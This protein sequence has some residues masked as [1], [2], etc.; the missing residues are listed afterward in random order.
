[1][2]HALNNLIKSLAPKDSVKDTT[3]LPKWI[4][5]KAGVSY[6]S[7]SGKLMDVTITEISMA[8]QTVTFTFDKDATTWKAVPFN[9]VLNSAKNPLKPRKEE[10]PAIAED[11]PESFFASLDDKWK[12]NMA[13]ENA[14]LRAFQALNQPKSKKP[15][16]KPQV[17]DGGE[18]GS[19]P[20]EPREISSSVERVSPKRQEKDDEVGPL[21]GPQL[22]PQQ[23]PQRPGT[24][25]SNKPKEHKKMSR[26]DRKNQKSPSPPPESK[27]R[28]RRQSSSPERQV[29]RQTKKSPSPQ[30]HKKRRGD[31]RRRRS[32]SGDRRHS[33]TG[34]RETRERSRS[35]RRGKSRSRSRRR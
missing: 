11:D 2:A 13:K 27:R 17:L 4:K 33:K 9:Q 30:V 18:I 10:A 26:N 34:E 15:K 16:K 22:G 5:L 25:D 24:G 3:S 35:R 32:R 19:S 1:M 12:T 28:S 20:S 14:P 21:Q 8:K 7:S 31:S 6:T 23:G 29:K